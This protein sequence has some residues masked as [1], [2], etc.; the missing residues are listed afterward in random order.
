VPEPWESVRVAG[1][2]PH[3]VPVNDWMDHAMSG[4]CWCHPRDGHEVWVHNS[5]DRREEYESGRLRFN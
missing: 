1:D 3:V 2:K 4:E 5:M